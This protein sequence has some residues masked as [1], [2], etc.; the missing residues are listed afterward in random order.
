LA[1]LFDNIILGCPHA[2]IAGRFAPPH[3]RQL[4]DSYA[5]RQ[6][7]TP[8]KYYF[9][10]GELYISDHF[11]NT[12][13][14]QI[15]FKNVLYH[16]K[17]V[18]LIERLDILL[19]E[20]ESMD[21]FRLL[22]RK[23]L[24]PSLRALRFRILHKDVFCGAK[25]FKIG[26]SA[27]PNCAVCGEI[28]TVQHQLFECSGPRRLWQYYNS[29]MLD[30]GRHDLQVFNFKEAILIPSEST[31]VTESLKSI[32]LKFCIQ[33][34][35]PNENSRVAFYNFAKQYFM[36]EILLLKR[37]PDKPRVKLKIRALEK[38]NK[39]LDVVHRSLL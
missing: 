37:K 32:V 18:D 22:Y 31:F 17:K 7:V 27:S 38:I 3:F 39:S 1:D 23:I 19:N 10:D 21:A 12:R 5:L 26:M 24:D 11:V 20:Q 29:V 28:E 4:Q 36:R 15:H 16:T 33:I 9:T 30:F 35:R 2:T 14:L 6:P 13:L 25:M 34:E 8:H